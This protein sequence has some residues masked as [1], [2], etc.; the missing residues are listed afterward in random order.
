MRG[1]A[2][3]KLKARRTVH[4]RAAVSAFYRADEVSPPV[5][6][7]VR[8]HTKLS[9][10]GKAEDG[11]DAVIV[12]GI[13]RLVFQETE[14]TSEGRVVRSLAPLPDGMVELELERGGLVEVP[15]L[16]AV[17]ELDHLEQPDG[18]LNIYWGVTLS[19]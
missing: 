1:I 13:N 19:S 16:N 7:T 18:P 12:E 8:W 10:A 4:D 5:E 15:S 3:A 11:F 17:F 2:S 6:L 9:L 14:L